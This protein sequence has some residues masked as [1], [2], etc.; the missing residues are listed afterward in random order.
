MKK[1]KVSLWLG[2]LLSRCAEWMVR[3]EVKYCGWLWGEVRW[4]NVLVI[5]L[6]TP[7]H[8]RITRLH[9]PKNRFVMRTTEFNL[10]LWRRCWH[11]RG[12]ER[13]PK[14]A[15]DA[16][17]R[18]CTRG[19][20]DAS[21]LQMVSAQCST[22]ESSLAERVLSVSCSCKAF[23]ST[24]VAPSSAWQRK[25]C[26]SL[27]VNSLSKANAIPPG[28]TPIDCRTL[29]SA[30]TCKGNADQTRTKPPTQPAWPT[31]HAPGRLPGPRA[32]PTPALSPDS[33][34]EKALMQ[35]RKKRQKQRQQQQQQQQQHWCWP[36]QLVKTLSR[37][38]FPQELLQKKRLSIKAALIFLC[39]FQYFFAFARALGLKWQIQRLAQCFHKCTDSQVLVFGSSLYRFAG[40]DGCKCQHETSLE[41]IPATQRV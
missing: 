4:D 36:R 34:S 10:V 1:D 22:N 2:T 14:L 25:L 17:L 39:N 3:G 30:Y 29:W 20:Q 13:T 19:Y 38:I 5:I 23:R 16:G 31:H 11:Q 27:Q 6:D 18:C 8:Q 21:E 24:S 41:Y 15:R 7:R 9:P 12:P 28:L 32:H 33:N 35:P 40:Q 26:C 37:L